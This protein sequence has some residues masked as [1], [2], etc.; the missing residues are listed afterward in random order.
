MVSS[1][2]TATATIARLVTEWVKN[3]KERNESRTRKREKRRRRRNEG[4]KGTVSAM[5]ATAVTE[6]CKNQIE[7][8][9]ERE[10]ANGVGFGFS[11][12]TRSTSITQ[13]IIIKT[14]D[15]Q[16]KGIIGPLGVSGSLSYTYIHIYI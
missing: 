4:R 1:T 10:C 13:L 3:Q 8:S 9:K 6:W 11:L 14:K 7:S 15:P 16:K 2:S 12:T 5:R